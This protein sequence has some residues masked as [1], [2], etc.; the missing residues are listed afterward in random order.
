MATRFQNDSVGTR[1]EQ[2]DAKQKMTPLRRRRGHRRWTRLVLLVAVVS[3]A[4][5]PMTG[6]TMARGLGRGLS[7]HEFLDELMIGYRNSAWSARAWLCRRDRYINHPYL[8]D[9]EAGF[10]AGYEAVAEGSNGC[11]PAVCPR[12]YWG[13][14]YQSA[15]GQKRMNA[16]FEAFPLGVQAAE[17]D[18]IGHWGHVAT[19]FV[20]A[21][22]CQ[23][24]PSGAKFAVPP[25][26]TAEAATL[27]A[28]PIDTLPLP[29]PGAV[30]HL[31]LPVYDPVFAPGGELNE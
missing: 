21:A 24:C 25:K 26:G 10:R 22:P 13:W 23:T 15:D 5:A 12:A 30:E 3:T 8:A 14:Q 9:F 27:P 1:T 29:T 20:G 31:P 6:C 28:G 19:A 18:G 2:T 7:Q 17:E 4:A 11:V 16:W